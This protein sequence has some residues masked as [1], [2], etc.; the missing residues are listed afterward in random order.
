MAGE[1]D[2]DDGLSDRQMDLCLS[3]HISNTHISEE[4][5]HQCQPVTEMLSSS[6]VRGA[7]P[8][9]SPQQGVPLLA[10]TQEIRLP[11]PGCN[12]LATSGD[13][14]V[15]ASAGWDCKVVGGV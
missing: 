14:R 11:A 9:T 6:C 8:Q 3:D 10:R 13:G 12:R 15:I 4:A 5:S 7:P 2:P 1:P